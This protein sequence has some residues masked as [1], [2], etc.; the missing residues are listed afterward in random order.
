M[1]NKRRKERQR[2]KRKTERSRQKKLFEMAR[3]KKE[4]VGHRIKEKRS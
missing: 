4:N 2:E 3:E 1:R